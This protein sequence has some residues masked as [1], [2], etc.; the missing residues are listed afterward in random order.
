[1]SERTSI[2]FG[3]PGTGKT[4]AL[5]KIVKDAL[6]AGS[7]PERIAF[8][9]FT[10][11]AASEATSRAAQAFGL[12]DDEL[13]WFRTLHSAAFKMLGLSSSEVMQ[14]GHYAELAKHL[15][16]FTFQHSYD[17][18]TERVPPGGGLGD[19]ALSI[20]T[21]ARS[22]CVSV[23]EEWCE[24]S[25]SN[26]T[27]KEMRQFA[28]ALDEYKA[29]Y[30]LL[31][32]SDFLDE[33]HEPLSLDL[34]IIDEAQDLTR[35][36]WN[37][38]R[39]IGAKAYQVVIAGDDD[40]A[41]FQW[42][43][44]DVSTFLNLKGNVRVLPISYRLPHDI[45]A[46]STAIAQGIRRRK[47]KNWQPRPDDKGELL[48]VDAPD[49]V[50]LRSNATWL[51]LTRL[52]WQLKMMEDI[53]RSQG[54]VYQMDHAWSNQ[55]PEVRAIVAYE[56]MRRGEAVQ[57]NRAAL[58][59]SYIPGLSQMPKQDTVEWKDV[60][61]PF[62]GMPD[63]MEALQGIGFEQREYIRKLRKNNES[64]INPGRVVLSTIH[65][66]KGG[67]ADNVLMLPDTS[68]RIDDALHVDQDSERRVWYVGA[69][70]AIHQLNICKPIST[71]NVF[72]SIL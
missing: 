50:D 10:R 70:R 36:Q 16:R 27:L 49:S 1:M 17:E 63:W 67:E 4:T 34:L 5:L 2:L 56:K 71:R 48:Y 43:G 26:L 37:F 64:L 11:K 55:T 42:A 7:L 59:G 69:S 6:D 53:C 65:G 31:D 60:P 14:D 3:P 20:Y 40:Q 33:V 8:F 23:D 47:V 46:K 19:I 15:G 38:A 57:G 44:A 58:V 39:R 24:A 54:V 62:E 12:K 68:K 22:R 18:N 61:W 32:F 9:A 13:P 29:A 52:R 72:G 35:Q 41:I 30:Q 25:E 51:M 66:V 28:K 45:W 21:R